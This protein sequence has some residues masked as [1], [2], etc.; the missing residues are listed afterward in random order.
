MQVRM[1]LVKTMI[2]NSWK[3]RMFSDTN[4]LMFYGR[5]VWEYLFD[6]DLD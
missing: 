1:D 4:S 6:K 3:Y 2:C 5:R